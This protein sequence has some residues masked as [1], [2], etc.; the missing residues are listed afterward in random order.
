[1][2]TIIT[3]GVIL[4]VYW[5]IKQAYRRTTDIEFR[6]NLYRL[7]DKLRAHVISGEIKEDDWFFDFMDTSI[8][9]SIE[10]V[11]SM[12]LF[13][14]VLLQLTNKNNENI[15]R[16]SKQVDN[17]ITH[18]QAARDI[19]IEYGNILVKHI[20]QKHY[21]LRFVFKLLRR[22]FLSVKVIQ[23]NY[24]NISEDVRQVA[25]YPQTTTMLRYSI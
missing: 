9:K 17:K 6:M 21:I 19:H 2:N 14:I 12:N 4:F 11:T 24:Y 18:N 20:F 16:F 3:I 8:C 23:D 15:A 13:S 25:I 7:R 1:M 5:K 10:K 22:I